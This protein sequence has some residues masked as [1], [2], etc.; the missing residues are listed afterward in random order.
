L[1]EW[2]EDLFFLELR[3]ADLCNQ[4]KDAPDSSMGDETIEKLGVSILEGTIF[5]GEISC[6]ADFRKTWISNLVYVISERFERNCISYSSK[7]KCWVNDDFDTVD[8]E[9]C[10]HLLS[11]KFVWLS[12]AKGSTSSIESSA[13]ENSV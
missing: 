12:I 11:F 10:P 6:F 3:I 1:Q 5:D 2:S 4:I 9:Y 13:D 8:G 7:A